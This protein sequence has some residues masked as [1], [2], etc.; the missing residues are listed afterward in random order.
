MLWASRQAGSLK[1]HNQP[2]VLFSGL[3]VLG[4]VKNP[5]SDGRHFNCGHKTDSASPLFLT[6]VI[7]NS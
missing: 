6:A 2:N 3:A 7:F 4:T 1:A 5:T